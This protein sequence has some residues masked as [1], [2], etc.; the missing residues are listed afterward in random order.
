MRC[1][2]VVR[3][4]RSFGAAVAIALVSAGLLTHEVGA[5]SHGRGSRAWGKYRHDLGNTGWS[6]LKGPRVT[7]HGDPYDDAQ[8]TMG[9]CGTPA[10]DNQGRIFTC[11]Y[12][13]TFFVIDPLAGTVDSLVIGA[14]RAT[15]LISRDESTAYIGVEVGPDY[16][17]DGVADA[18]SG[19][20]AI[21]ISAS[22]PTELWRLSIG[23]IESSATYCRKNGLI[24]V[25]TQWNG[26]YSIDPSGTVVAN[27][28]P[29]VVFAASPVLI[30]KKAGRPPLLFI[31]GYD[32]LG[33]T[34]TMF[35]YDLDLTLG[36][37]WQDTF[38]GSGTSLYSSPAYH[39]G[40]DLI[41]VGCYDGN[42]YSYD[43]AGTRATVLTTGDKI[44]ASPAI[45][46][47]GEIFVTS[48][49]GILHVLDAT[50]APLWTYNT[51]CACAL[52]SPTVDRRNRVYFG[53][54]TMELF[55]VRNASLEWSLT[56]ANT[57]EVAIVRGKRLVVGG[58]DGVH[59][60]VE[61]H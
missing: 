18:D 46:R 56:L 21:D 51:G 16:D 57:L 2:D 35:C 11:S 58:H 47:N 34:G 19:F 6:R 3:R 1:K 12:D 7:V 13:G 31:G 8:Y 27:D 59:I 24:Y 42:L 28:S 45:G 39:K 17:G 23:T 54:G 49:D 53:G 43:P 37:I 25:C 9:C 4:R 48:D 38:A 52:G 15:P 30:P 20:V 44:D 50:E 61:S 36:P 32:S 22:P 26:I 60:I 14:T 5:V 10:V 55:C 29:G 33:G 41:Y 40:N